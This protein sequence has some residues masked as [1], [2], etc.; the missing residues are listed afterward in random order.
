MIWPQVEA[1]KCRAACWH[2][3][4]HASAAADET[5]PHRQIQIRMV[6][7]DPTTGDTASHMV[8]CTPARALAGMHWCGCSQLAFR[9]LI[10]IPG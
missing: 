6:L 7:G 8:R 4:A 10:H 5:A 3:D 1:G 2:G 9:Q